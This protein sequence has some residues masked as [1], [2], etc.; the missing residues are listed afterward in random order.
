MPAPLGPLGRHILLEYWRERRQPEGDSE[1]VETAAAAAADTLAYLAR[2]AF[3][4]DNLVA[5]G[6]VHSSPPEEETYTRSAEA[7]VAAL[8]KANCTGPPP[9]VRIPETAVRTRVAVCNLLLLPW[10]GSHRLAPPAPHTILRRPFAPK[11]PRDFDALGTTRVPP[12]PARQ[13]TMS[14]VRHVREQVP[15]LARVLLVAVV[16]VEQREEGNLP[17]C[18]VVAKSRL[19]RNLP[20]C[21]NPDFPT[22]QPANSDPFCQQSREDSREEWCELA[23]AGIQRLPKTT[24]PKI[25]QFAVA[26]RSICASNT[27]VFVPKR[28]LSWL[29]DSRKSR[30]WRQ[31]KRDG[32]WTYLPSRATSLL[33]PLKVILRDVSTAFG[34]FTHIYMCSFSCVL[35]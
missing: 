25:G 13:R 27:C 35:T 14:V 8:H 30:E 33:F 4:A 23:R 18:P 21:P 1:K 22:I 10:R 34:D 7:A 20:W 2:V 28:Q 15:L 6:A 12:P 26:D 19:Q 24:R 9:V 32:H 17:P 16:A 31:S 3:A 5:V 29:Q 11:E